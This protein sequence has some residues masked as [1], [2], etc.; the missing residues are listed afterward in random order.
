MDLKDLKALQKG[1]VFLNEFK[2]KMAKLDK[3]HKLLTMT[4]N[5]VSRT[6]SRINAR[7]TDLSKKMYKALE[8]EQ[9]ARMSL[10][11]YV[12]SRIGSNDSELTRIDS[13]LD[14]VVKSLGGVKDTKANKADLAELAF[15]M[16][17]C[18]Q[19]LKNVET[20]WGI[21]CRNISG[22]KV[23]FK[24]SECG[25]DVS[26]DPHETKQ[27]RF[28]PSCGRKVFEAEDK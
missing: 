22:S 18:Y 14:E 9:R 20:R 3:G 2:R 21:Y 15:E 1:C 16:A 13:R 10:R 24:C 28:C 5:N 23:R 6:V 8:E 7:V 11:D 12:A 17:K 27:W 4:L 25:Y 19:R 26:A